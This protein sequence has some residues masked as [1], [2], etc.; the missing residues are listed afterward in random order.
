M[1]NRYKY[2]PLEKV[3]ITFQPN[4]MYNL[5]SELIFEAP[6]FNKK[7]LHHIYNTNNAILEK[8]SKNIAI[9]ESEDYD[10]RNL[11]ATY[12]IC[13]LNGFHDAKN[14]LEQ[15]KPLLRIYDT[16]IY[17]SYKATIRILRKIKYS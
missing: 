14:K 13:Y 7:T 6:Q 2:Y 10:L 12:M 9:N 4:G 16:D 17:E 11:P 1:Q 15:V 3:T 5:N 8:L